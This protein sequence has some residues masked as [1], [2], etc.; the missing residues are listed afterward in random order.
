[1]I[2][3]STAAFHYWR[4][5]RDRWPLLLDRI[6]EL[7]FEA[8]DTYVPWAIHMP[9]PDQSDW[10]EKNPDLDL[11]AFVGLCQDHGLSV[12]LR[13][14][15]H[16]NAELPN[17]GIPRWVL[18]D[19]A[20]QARGPSGDLVYPF[21]ISVPPFPIPSYASEN[22]FR[23]TAVWLDEALPRI[24]PFLK[25]N[26]G[27]V[28]SLQV[29]NELDYFFRPSPFEL[30][31]HP[32]AIARYKNWRN[33]P[34]AE[35]PR[36]F[37][38]GD[39][40]LM[41]DWCRFKE[42]LL[43][44]SLK[45]LATMYHERGI[46]E[47]PLTLNLPA[48]VSRGVVEPGATPLDMQAMERAVEIVGVDLYSPPAAYHNTSK[49]SRYL[50]ATSRFPF[51]PEFGAGR[52]DDWAT[53]DPFEAAFNWR[54]V[55]MHGARALSHYM[56]VE[57]D[58][59]IE[60][61]IGPEG[62]LRP[63]ASL[64]PP[65]NAL[66]RALAGSQK[67]VNL[68][69][70]PVRDYG[71]FAAVSKLDAPRPH[72]SNND[73]LPERWASDETFGFTRP[74]A[75]DDL[76]WFR[77]VEAALVAG[78]YTSDVGDDDLPLEQLQ[79]YRAI[80]A[81]A[82]DFMSRSTQKKLLEYV[83]GGGHLIYGPD[84]PHLDEEMRPYRLL[85]DFPCFE[86]EPDNPEFATQLHARL[87]EAGLHPAAERDDARIDIAIHQ[88]PAGRQVLFAVNPTPEERQV[89]IVG[90]GAPFEPATPAASSDGSVRLAPLSIGIWE[91][92]KP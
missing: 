47:V 3:A 7:G 62:E 67:L 39:I 13:P 27:P 84:R 49:W 10:G 2:P 59:W 65:H 37:D 15:P 28:T 54:A 31:Y 23:H 36:R 53:R 70:M 51:V 26:G 79:R 42:W 56:I 35:P 83:R 5:R 61:P 58:R 12:S 40:P 18:Y 69:V 78:G 57:R 81:P 64:Y 19:P 45:R 87:A 88:L 30:D 24:V 72:P 74:I 29:D 92:A 44:R 66:Q 76:A 9:T 8:V 41:L 4:S 16:V 21:D 71:R 85:A 75:R 68:L 33:D 80:I 60:T 90:I 6:L 25:P 82:F 55:L 22:F 52:A 34:T 14:G 11:A 89:T 1:M 43:T 48:L 73:Y 86:T 46:N 38:P 77:A 17:F 50:H 32:D 20:V 91:V 63:Q